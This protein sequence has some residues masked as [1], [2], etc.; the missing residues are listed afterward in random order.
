MRVTVNGREAEVVARDLA[1]LLDEMEYEFTQL[2]IAVNYRVVPR[3]RWAQTALQPGD[4]IEILTP[5][6]GG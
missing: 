3:A 5:R 2:A 1:A 4:E 6:Q